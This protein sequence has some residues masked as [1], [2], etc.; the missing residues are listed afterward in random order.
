MIGTSTWDLV[1][2]RSC[3]FLLRCI[4]PLGILYCLIAFLVPPPRFLIFKVLEVWC[5]SEAAFYLL[6][7]LPRKFYLQAPATHPTLIPRERRRDLFHRCHENVSDPESYLSKWFRDAERSE[8]KKENV[9]DFL[10]WAFLNKGE[11]D[12]ADD[13]EL[14]EYI[15]GIES[16]LGR[17]LKD[18]RGKAKCLRLTVDKVDML[19][20]SLTWYLCVFVVDTITYVSMCYHSFRPYG[21]S[22]RRFPTVFPFRPLTLLSPYRSPAKTLSYWYRPHTSKTRLPILFIHG[23]GIGLYP[24]VNFLAD[25]N[26]KSNVYESDGEVGIIA[27]EIM[28][29]SFRITGGALPKEEMCNEILSILNKHGW[30]KVVLLSHSYGSVI[31]THLLHTPQLAERIGPILYVDPVSFLLHLPDVAYNF[32]YRKPKRANEHQLHYFACKDMGVSHTLS[33]HFFW[34]E[35]I[36]WKEDIK[37]RRVTVA[38][39]ENDS[40]VNTEAVGTYLAGVEDDDEEEEDGEGASWKENKLMGEGLE[41]LWLP[42]LDHAQAFDRDWA[43]ERLVSVV[44]GY[45]RD[46]GEGGIRI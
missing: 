42:G 12:P 30:E 31:S 14:D 32:T 28:P 35:N 8:I 46:G 17:K 37:D 27:L 23:I 43:K 19:H 24:Y 36:L 15:V 45:C 38:L 10:R 18:G 13:E 44:L 29:V 11:F 3:I 26:A 5:V 39:A 1:F 20:R 21:T 25:L 33:R 2:I 6:L 22:L 9:K 34:S 16:M 7:Y 40:I 41:V 4:A